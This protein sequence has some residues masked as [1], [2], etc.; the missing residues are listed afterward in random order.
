MPLY[1]YECKSCKERFELRRSIADRD[2]ELVCPKCGAK[3]P[4][5]LFSVFGMGTSSSSNIPSG[6]SCST[7]GF[8]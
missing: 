5:R 2:D 6:Q 7:G 8:S 4:R 1:E 3:N